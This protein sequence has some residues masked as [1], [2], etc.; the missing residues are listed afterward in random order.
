MQTTRAVNY[1]ERDFE[2]FQHAGFSYDI[3]RAGVKSIPTSTTGS[4][5]WLSE[6]SL[7]FFTDYHEFD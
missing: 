6:W 5:T 4:L 2:L 1:S 7:H 3:S